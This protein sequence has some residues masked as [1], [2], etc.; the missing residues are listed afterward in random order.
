MQWNFMCTIC[1]CIHYDGCNCFDC[2]HYKRCCCCWWWR[3]WCCCFRCF[4]YCRCRLFHPQSVSFSFWFGYMFSSY[5]ALHCEMRIVELDVPV[6]SFPLCTNT[7]LHIDVDEI[8]HA[9][10]FDSHSFFIRSCSTSLTF[11]ISLS[12]LFLVHFE[13]LLF[14]LICFYMVVINHRQ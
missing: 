4:C 2:Y 12:L 11:T 13:C 3:W 10:S 1:L 6:L 14:L 5:F 8:V 7:R 9:Q